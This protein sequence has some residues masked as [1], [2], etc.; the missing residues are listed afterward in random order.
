MPVETRAIYEFGPYRLDNEDGTLTR[1]GQPVHLPPKAA[2]VLVCLLDQAG[3]VVSKQ[4]LS[5][6]VW[7]ETTVVPGTLNY[8]IHVIRHALRDNTGETYIE[9]VPTRGFR[10]VAPVV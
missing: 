5:T 3:T 6:H 10:F 7:P 9:T 2:D 1:H 4:A 8:Q